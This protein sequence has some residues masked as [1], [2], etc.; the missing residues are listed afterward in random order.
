MGSARG[1]AMCGCLPGL[2]QRGDGRCVALSACSLDVV[3][4]F[5]RAGA[6]GRDRVGG[7]LV[8]AQSPAAG[9]DS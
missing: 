9:A 7:P 5:Y 3:R 8:R 1:R 4:A 2:A 6:A